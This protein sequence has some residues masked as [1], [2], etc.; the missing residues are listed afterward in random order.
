MVIQYHVVQ[1]KYC[2]KLLYGFQRKEGK[3]CLLFV[4]NISL[5][6]Y[7]YITY[8]NQDLVH[9]LIPLYERWNS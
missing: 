5:Y 9:K 3:E 7:K 1:F 8:M 6:K 2:T 4:N